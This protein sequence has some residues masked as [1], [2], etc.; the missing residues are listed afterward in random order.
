M[1]QRVFEHCMQHC[2]GAKLFFINLC[3]Q[4]CYTKLYGVHA[5]IVYINVSMYVVCIVFVHHSYLLV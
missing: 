5:V 4:Y 3:V 2:I 1:Y